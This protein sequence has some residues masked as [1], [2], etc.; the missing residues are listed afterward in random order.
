MSDFLVRDAAARDASGIRDIYNDA[1]VNTNAIWNEQ[2]VDEAKAGALLALEDIC[3]DVDLQGGTWD[4]AQATAEAVYWTCD[5]S[6]EYIA[7]RCA[8][9]PRSMATTVRKATR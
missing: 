6:E 7:V 2:V 5:F 4:A 3:I 8:T 1:V 9:N